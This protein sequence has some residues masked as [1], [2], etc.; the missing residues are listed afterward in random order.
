MS[1]WLCGVQSKRLPPVV[2]LA[3]STGVKA[4]VESYLR[5]GRD[6]DATD[7]KDRT[8]LLLAAAGGSADVCR[9]LLESGADPSRRDAEGSDALTVAIRNGNLDAASVLRA[10]LAPAPPVHRARRGE[11][12]SVT[13]DVEFGTVAEDDV[14]GFDQWE[15]L[16][17][18]P[19]PRDDPTLRT[20]AAELQNRISEHAPIDTDFDWSDVEIELPESA[21]RRDPEYAFWLDAVRSL[22]HFGLSWGWV[23]VWQVAGVAS[24]SGGR[25]D[26]D[27]IES[28]LR[29]VLGDVGILVEDD[30]ALAPIVNQLWP[31]NA[32]VVSHGG[33]MDEAIAFIDNLSQTRDLR[34]Y[35]MKDI[36]QMEAAVRSLREARR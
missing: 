15:A 9:L 35:Y 36:Q 6:P 26:V 2:R 21:T 27:E 32:P 29:L 19:P 23:T 4:P 7:A 18:P 11:G 8:L 17:E 33:I 31:E 20:D 10:C 1:R 25:G 13:S 30:P 5:A 22:I 12:S 16:T 3:A 34:T 28:R 24:D 14:L